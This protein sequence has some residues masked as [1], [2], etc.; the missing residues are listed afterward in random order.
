MN[1]YK[2]R[3]AETA[4]QRDEKSSSR[5]RCKECVCPWNPGIELMSRW[6]FDTRT[7]LAVTSEKTQNEEEDRKRETSTLA[8]EDQMQQVKN[9]LSS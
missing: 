7:H 1:A 4:S 5:A 3:I 8:T 2:D 6:R 9:N